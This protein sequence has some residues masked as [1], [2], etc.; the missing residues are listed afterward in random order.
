MDN[1]LD[2]WPTSPDIWPT[3][4]D[5]VLGIFPVQIDF[6]ITNIEQQGPTVI[7]KRLLDVGY[8]SLFQ[9]AMAEWRLLGARPG[10][11]WHCNVIFNFI[12]PH[13]LEAEIQGLGFNELET[14][15]PGDQWRV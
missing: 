4:L 6:L 2:A 11:G 1:N 8:E 12:D 14:C 7:V 3:K 5:K 10:P 9:N 15:Q 13:G